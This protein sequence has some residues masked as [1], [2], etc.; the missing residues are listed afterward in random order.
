MFTY[1]HSSRPRLE[2]RDPANQVRPVQFCDR[3][4]RSCVNVM[5]GSM[6]IFLIFYLDQNQFCI[7][8]VFDNRY[9]D[10]IYLYTSVHSSGGHLDSF[11][12]ICQIVNVY[13]GGCDAYSPYHANYMLEG[14][15]LGIQP[16]R[17]PPCTL[18]RHEGGPN[19]PPPLILRQGPDRRCLAPHP[20]ALHTEAGHA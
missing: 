16:W 12:C 20:H 11:A 2:L 5:F 15:A 8:L 18:G 17:H 3:M 19:I 9:T 6:I 7:C 4:R 13:K 10:S 14:P 1:I